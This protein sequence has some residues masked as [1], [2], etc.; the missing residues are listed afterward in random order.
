VGDFSEV[1]SQD[2]Y[3]RAAEIAAAGGHNL[4]VFGPPGA[5]KTMLAR[6]MPSIM[7]PLCSWESVEVTRLHS[8]AGR[9]ETGERRF[10]LITHPPFRSPH[11]SASAEGLLGGGKMVRPGEISLAHFGL[12]FLDEAPEFRSNV[13]QALRE[14]LE[15]R[16]VTIS[17]AEGPVRLPADFQ[18]ILAA[19]PCPCGRLGLRFSGGAS[20]T[21]CFCSP[22]EI[23]RYWR[24]FGA[25]F[26]DRIEL[27]VAVMPP[28][29]TAAPGR[30]ESS[31]DIARRVN[32][33]VE[34]QRD[35]FKNAPAG[36]PRRNAR[37]SPAQ[38][39]RC[40]GLSGA[41]GEAFRKA[42]EKLALSGRALHQIL[43]VARTI[44]DLEER[45]GIEAVHILEAVQHRRPGEDPYDVLRA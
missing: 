15:D 34:I 36:G 1:R 41:A 25:A 16:V 45:D 4:L 12:L 23:H 26:L 3:K 43:R 7:P 29:G 31:A 18:L 39:D 40:C 10:G 44:A 11:H 30:E 8:L 5:G 32:G 28:G 37:M 9:L 27:R 22:E 38:L 42:A 6:R 33:A 20:D 21:G 13:L 17:R 19:N 2:R 24:K 14:P 35:R